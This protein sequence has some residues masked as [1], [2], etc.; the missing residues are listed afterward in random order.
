MNIAAHFNKESLKTKG[1]TL[2]LEHSPCCL[3][4]FGAGVL[5]AY[6]AFNHNPVLEFGFAVGGAIAG[7]HFG[8]K[9]FHKECCI[10]ET[11]RGTVKRYSMALCF[12][13]ASWGAHQVLLHDHNDTEEHNHQI[14]QHIHQTSGDYDC[15]HAPIKNMLSFASPDAQKARKET[16]D[17]KHE[18]ECNTLEDLMPERSNFK[19]LKLNVMDTP[20][21]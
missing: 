15:N 5:G 19:P 12:G 3:L 20:A 9:W 2:L 16:H 11:W 4:I 17:K 6:S 18:Q 21:L 13:V 8:H 7:E 1:F 10:D 14:T